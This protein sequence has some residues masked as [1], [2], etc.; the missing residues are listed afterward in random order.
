ME[1]NKVTESDRRRP[2]FHLGK[3]AVEEFMPGDEMRSTPDVIAKPNLLKPEESIDRPLAECY[4]EVADDEEE[5][6]MAD[7]RRHWLGR[8]SIVLTGA[9]V[10]FILL[11]VGLAVPSLSKGSTVGGG[12]VKALTGIIFAGVAIFVGSGTYIAYWVYNHSR[13]LITNENVIEV[14]Q[15]SL[16]AHK[17]SHLN[18]INVEDVTVVK[19][20][21]LQTF[22]DYGLLQIETAGEKDNFSF[23]N[24]PNPDKYRRMV[25]NAHEKAIERVG[26]M[27]SVQRV[28]ITHNSL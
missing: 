17:V 15:M 16:F 28:A 1:D 26:E 22:F 8:I 21:I 7:V 4:P 12:N 3:E 5:T 25:I 24:T 20:G 2:E 10:I 9:F 6:L 23:P 11:A 14:R 19:R 13:L 27:G 18:M